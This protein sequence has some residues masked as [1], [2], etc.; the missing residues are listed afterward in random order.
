[1]MR[2]TFMLTVAL[3]LLAGTSSGAES[4][5][6]CGAQVV[7]EVEAAGESP[8]AAKRTWQWDARQCQQI[9]ESLRAGFA[10]TD[11]CKPI[12]GGSRVLV[13]SSS[14]G[15]ALVE[16]P[17]GKVTWYA[18]V[19]NA[20]SLELLPEDRIVVASS[21]HADGNRL[22]LFDLGRPDHPLWDTPLTSA[23]GVVWD[24][25]RQLLWALGLE[26]LRAYALA[27]WKSEKPSLSLQATYPLPGPDGHDLQPVPGNA[28]L[29]VTTG[30][31]V[32]LFDRD[33]HAFRLHPQ[34]GERPIVKSVS[35]HPVTRQ[36]VFIQASTEA[37]WTDRLSFLAPEASL[38]LAGE[39]LYKARWIP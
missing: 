6:V 29:V 22:V 36:T 25:Q 23:H 8:E 4:L 17:S 34:L 31:H 32:Y 14:G 18:R 19:P 20:H 13:S 15:C 5:L 21:V 37:W 7:F 12:D 38:P 24:S 27:D 30:E 2:Y 10:S 11:D 3:T 28:D 9:P 16:R 35:I 33:A 1:M 39:R 26:E